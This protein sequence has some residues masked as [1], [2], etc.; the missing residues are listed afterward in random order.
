MKY[1]RNLYKGRI[2]RKNYIL[3]FL[4]FIISFGILIAL[5]LSAEPSGE[6]TFFVI[7]LI[8]LYGLFLDHMFSL[9]IRRLHDMGKSGWY[10][11]ILFIPLAIFY[12][13]L[14]KGEETANKYGNVP[15]KNR[16]FFNSIFNLKYSPDKSD[17]DNNKSYK[18]CAHCGN[19]I[20]V[21][22]KFCS[23]CGKNTNL[24]VS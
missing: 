22:S 9:H 20:E 6:S 10:I 2:G 3:G 1:L 5:L 11:F 7:C 12:L 18:F 4:F 24:I 16:G 15:E 8:L 21:D 13:L 23:G 14:G 19:K 17:F